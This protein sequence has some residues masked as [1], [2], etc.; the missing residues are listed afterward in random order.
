VVIR[1]EVAARENGVYAHA[2]AER[3]V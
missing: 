3:G 1:V 2:P